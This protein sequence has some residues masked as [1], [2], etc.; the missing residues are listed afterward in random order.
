MIK[1][2]NS[3]SGKLALIASVGDLLIA[4]EASRIVE[5]RPSTEVEIRGTTGNQEIR[6]GSDFIPA[7]SVLTLCGRNESS[8]VAAWVI[9]MIRSTNQPKGTPVALGVGRCIAVHLLPE[10]IALPDIFA[11]R[12]G[13]IAAA[14]ATD[15]FPDIVDY[16]SGLVIDPQAIL[17]L[18]EI[19]ILHTR[20]RHSA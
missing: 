17:T 16:P 13:A 4:I 3:A 10:C 20:S 8:V 15:S 9:T 6:N 12:P 2:A 5:I 14:F 18:D 19:A 11:Q 1:S 7:R